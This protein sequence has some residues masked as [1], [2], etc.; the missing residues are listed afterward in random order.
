[1]D[2]PKDLSAYELCL[3]QTKT[4]RAMHEIISSQLKSN[5]LTTMEWLLLNTIAGSGK[6]GMQMSKIAN[7]LDVTLPQVTTLTT[8]LVSSR[9]VYQKISTNDSRVRNLSLTLKGKRLLPKSDKLIEEAVS[10][11]SRSITPDQMR[12]YAKVLERLTR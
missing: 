6:S 12:M 7:V 11:W 8:K 1:M 10:S 2:K 5:K 4:N 3:L 9:L